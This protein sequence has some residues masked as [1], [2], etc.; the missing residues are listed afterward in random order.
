M[1]A[2]PPEAAGQQGT[3]PRSEPRQVAAL[4]PQ[5]LHDEPHRS[6]ETDSDTEHDQHGGR[7]RSV[8]LRGDPDEPGHGGD[9][10]EPVEIRDRRCERLRRQRREHEGQAPA[11]PV[12]EVPTDGVAEMKS[13]R[14]L[15]TWFTRMPRLISQ[16]RPGL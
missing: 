13:G 3:R 7:G 5:R 16:T 4:V 2:V 11:D 15:P 14:K 12:G 9:D 6:T 8:D 10:Q 1:P